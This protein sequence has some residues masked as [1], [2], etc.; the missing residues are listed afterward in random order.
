MYFSLIVNKYP[1]LALGNLLIRQRKDSKQTK[2]NLRLI[3]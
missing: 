3:L 2:L 1:L